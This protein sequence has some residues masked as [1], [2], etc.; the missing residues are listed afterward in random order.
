MSA[1]QSFDEQLLQRLPLPLAQLCRRSQNA[2]TPLEQ[3]LAAYY[4]WEASLKLLGAT[5]VVEYAALKDRDPEIAEKLK[6]LARPAVGHWWEFVRRLVPVLA[7]KGDKGFGNVRDLVLGRARDDMPRAAGLFAGLVEALE[8]KAGARSTVRLTELF[9]RLVTYRNREIGHGAAGQRPMDFY[10]RMAGTLTM[11]FAQILAK[12][13]VIAGRRIIYIGD[14]RR[15]ANGG[16]LI[17]RYLLVNETPRRLEPLLLTE[18]ETVCLPRPECVY[19]E[20][21]RDMRIASPFPTL[22]SLHPLVHFEPDA[23]KLFFLNARRG[24]QQV[25]YLCYSTGETLLRDIGTDQRELL[26]Q[27][28]NQPIDASAVEVF[29]ARSLAEEKADDV[30]AASPVGRAIGEYE[31]LSRLGQG[32]MGVVYRAWQPSLG[33]QVALKCMLRVNDPKSEARFA[34]EIRALGRIEHPNVVKVFTSG[35]DGDQWF[36]AMELIEGAELSRVCEHLTGSSAADIDAARWQNAL[37]A[38]CA[39]VRTQETQLSKSKSD[40]SQKIPMAT[41]A[42]PVVLGAS[43][44]HGVP[45]AGR[46][47]VRQVVDIVRQVSAAVHALHEAGVV[48]RDIKPG[49]IMLTA[50]GSHPVLMDLGLAQ[51][52]DETDGKLTRTRQFV[53]TLRYASPEQILAVGDVDRRTDVYSL[54]VTL[55]ELLTLR[56]AFGA[57][58][59]MPTPDLMLKIQTTDLESPRK[60]NRNIPRDLAAIVSKCV[61]KDRTQRYAT[62]SDLAAD[63]GRFLN[64][65]PVAAQPPSF[66]YV[67]GKFVRRHKVPLGT[68]A[69]IFLLLITGVVASFFRINAERQDAVEARGREEREREKA[70][71]AFQDLNK[72]RKEAE[73]VWKVV[74]QAYSSVKEDNIRHL[75]GLSPVHEEL[76]AIRLEGMQQLAKMTP[77]D[78]TVGPKIARAHALLGL[79]SSYVGSFQRAQENLEKAAELYGQLA[80]KNPDTREYRLYECRACGDLAWLY[81]DDNQKS[82]ARRWVEQA[83][84]RLELEYAQSPDTDVCYELGRCLTQQGGC[85]PDD[86]TKETRLRLVTRAISIYE[87]MI[88]QKQREL[89]ARAG[90]A[91]A[92]YRLVMAQADDKDQ[93]TLLKSLAE[94]SA[95]D[96]AALRLAPNSPYLSSFGV[97]MHLDRARAL[98]R[99]GRPK[100]ALTELEAA[101]AKNREIVK[102]SPDTVRYADIHAECLHE[103][104]RGQQRLKRAADA[105]A[106]YEECRQVMDRLVTRFPDRAQTASMWIWLRN[107]N[108]DFLEYGPK[109][110]GEIQAKQD[111]LRTLDQA[112]G[113]G[114]D[115]AARFPDHYF[116]QT[117]FAKSLANRGRYDN[118]AKRYELALPYL[119]EGI[120]VYRTRVLRIN[121]PPQ[122]ADITEYLNQIQWAASCAANLKKTDEVIRLSQL[123][124]EMRKHCTSRAAVDDLGSVLVAAGKVHRE[125]GRYEKAVQAYRQAIEIRGPASEKAPWHWY[126]RTNYGGSYMHLADTYR[127]MKDFH[128]EVLANR[129]YLRIIIGP[130]Y[131]ARIDECVDPS[132][133]SDEQEAN[134]IRELIKKATA[135]GMKRFTVPC[136]FNGVKYPFHVYIVNSPWP[137]HPLEDQARWLL[138]ERGGVIPAEVMD[139]FA[140]LHKIAHENKVSFVDLCVYALGT[141]AAEQGTELSIE[142]AG[143]NP[144]TMG[145]GALGTPGKSAGDPLADLK[146]RLVDLKTKVDNAPGD[147][148]LATEAAQLYDE[149]GQRLL[150]GKQPREALDT[151]RASVKMREM[152]ARAQPRNTK[153]RQDLAAVFLLLGKAHAQLNELDAAFNCFHRRLDILEQLLAET[154]S[155]ELKSSV[156]EAQILFGELAE[157]RG[158]RSDAMRWYARAAQQMGGR[159]SYKTA[160]LLQLS[161]ELALLMPTEL[162]S[163]YS[164]LKTAG[165]TNGATFASDFAKAVEVAYKDRRPLGEMGQ[166]TAQQIAAL[167]DLAGHYSAIAREYSVQGRQADRRKALNKEFDIRAQQ[168]KLNP[169]SF[170]LQDAQ[171]RVAAEIARSHLESKETEAAATWIARAG[172]SARVDSLFLLADYYEMGIG[173]KADLMK[174]DHYRYLGH[175]GRGSKSFVDRRFK[176]ALPDLKKASEFPEAIPDDHDMLGMCYGKLG[177]WDEAIGSYQRAFD[178]DPNS[179]RGT[180]TALNLLEAF[181]VSER[182][183]DAKP[184]ADGLAQKKWQPQGNWPDHASQRR[185]LFYGFQAI[186]L[187]C[188]GK[189]ADDMEKLMRQHT[190]LTNMDASSWGWYEVNEWLKTTKLAP[191]RMARIERLLAELKGVTL[192]AENTALAGLSDSLSKERYRKVYSVPLSSGKT[193]QVDVTGEFD[194]VLRVEDSQQ[195]DSVQNDDVN[196]LV[197]N[198]N[199][200]LI[201]SPTKD[202]SYRL[203]VTSFKAGVIGKF[204]LKI[205]DVA[206]VGKEV[207]IKGEL[208]AKD[209]KYL[210]GHSHKHKIQLEAGRPYTIELESEKYGTRLLLFDPTGTKQAAK[211]EGISPTNYRL[212]RIDFTPQ[213]TATYVIL[214]TSYDAGKTGPYTL[215][216]QGYGPRAEKK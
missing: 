118:E 117:N 75:P 145:G 209:E 176:E 123:G 8:G 19:L 16:W 30:P 22:R 91:V 41:L 216:V 142:N 141:A 121:A 3:H 35:A 43:T 29:A 17:E 53:G 202:D 197:P 179:P 70:V 193:Y 194:T 177:Q 175:F 96:E 76:A 59:N 166:A 88:E 168:L 136:D 206:K 174:A 134:R 170:V 69:A 173:T 204:T 10:R 11:G 161:P 54:G 94:V 159:A 215:R 147:I 114:R 143:E 144:T 14:V 135:G 140:K 108:S 95:L 46:D 107:E 146:A 155:A 49:N 133:P 65:E 45:I 192:L 80:K 62:A 213:V 148:K 9:D 162:Q 106:T 120:E 128:N 182:F 178:L 152:L 199:S 31:L 126:L 40:S 137:K 61:E 188:L 186:A 203:I 116:L 101:V 83:L 12:L 109:P 100:E 68:A 180:G 18:K 183:A 212:S 185:A 160:N 149:V 181:I 15:L 51:L 66:R 131:G 99:L 71:Q 208:T 158:D 207:A 78:P 72:S 6:N 74:D 130:W 129:E 184:F 119:L 214:V 93:E 157:M 89:D 56:P 55:W 113:R 200:R 60:H 156:T 115:L 1:N 36:Y 26:G 97:F 81:W 172:N 163:I 111:L 24:K 47:H 112:V 48:H 122:Q 124:L 50:D 169:T 4:L 201:F 90:L 125:A 86:A 37:T 103:L 189:D 187:L 2:K 28:L 20:G 58:D 151:L 210:N 57:N 33:R 42:G 198:L 165:K 132:R 85:L 77:D 82:I 87:K 52:A 167:N 153:N 25:E 196:A 190:A 195:K 105:Q 84:T 150:K 5:A 13:D 34:R 32:G 21:R 139:S 205:Q 92:R 104:A 102:R 27:I 63:L 211:N 191:D 127:E 171:A 154:P 64:G 38:A 39:E 110:Q 79:I 44:P 138:E 67:A 7:D 73:V 164:T 98:T 23:A